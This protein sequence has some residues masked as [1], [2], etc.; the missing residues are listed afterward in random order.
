MSAADEAMEQADYFLALASAHAARLARM[1]T[2]G[3]DE[4]GTPNGIVEN[5]AR[6][7]LAQSL[8][9]A[10]DA[11]EV[12]G[13]E[14]GDLRWCGITAL[15]H[16]ASSLVWSVRQPALVSRVGD[17]LDKLRHRVVQL[18]HHPMSRAVG[19]RMA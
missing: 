13:V 11:V 18:R 5:Y 4:N 3:H 14:Q 17:L 2:F 9:D 12:L 7:L 16:G 10:S 19:V 8:R 6:H 1:L 15:L